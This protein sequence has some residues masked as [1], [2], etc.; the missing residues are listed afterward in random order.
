[1]LK[2]AL[3]LLSSLPTVMAGA[4]DEPPVRT[5]L[6]LRVLRMTPPSVIEVELRNALSVPLRLFK[7]DNS[8]GAARWRIMRIRNGDAAL[9]FQVPIEG[10][11]VNTP[12]FDELPAHARLQR[13]LDLAEK[14]WRSTQAV[15]MGIRAGDLVIPFYDVPVTDQ[16]RRG[17]VWYG[18]VAASMF[19]QQ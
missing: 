16:A 12:A 4:A 19:V 15:D 7:E 14:G 10:F 1:M 13:V 11:T 5:G 9:F 3:C 6:E 18:A 2:M 17:G 8:W